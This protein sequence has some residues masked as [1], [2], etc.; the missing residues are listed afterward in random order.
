MD[1]YIPISILSK[2]YKKPRKV[3]CISKEHNIYW[4]YK[5]DH[6]KDEFPTTLYKVS[7]EYEMLE[8]ESK[9]TFKKWATSFDL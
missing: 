3:Y 2:G 9:D 7:K 5:Q 1:F 8:E 6:I 4:A